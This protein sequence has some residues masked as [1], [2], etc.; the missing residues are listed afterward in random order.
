MLA[1]MT[2]SVADPL[3]FSRM[4]LISDP[5]RRKKKWPIESGIQDRDVKYSVADPGYCLSTH[6]GSGSGVKKAPD[7]RD[8]D[9]QYWLIS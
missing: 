3:C 2:S 4:V 6:P 7:P 1:R 9:P 5:T 8:P